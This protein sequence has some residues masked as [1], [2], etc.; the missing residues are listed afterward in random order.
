VS[1]K[2]GK[3]ERERRAAWFTKADY[4]RKGMRKA[5][6]LDARATLRFWRARWVG[7]YINASM[8]ALID[9]VMR[10]DSP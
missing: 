10:E 4:K 7:P 8:D 3:R 2:H 6:R 9:S 5:I 1:S